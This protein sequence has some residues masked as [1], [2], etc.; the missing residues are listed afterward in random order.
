MRA[1]FFV[2]L[3]VGSVCLVLGVWSLLAGDVRSGVLGVFLAGILFYYAHRR[4]L[5]LGRN[6]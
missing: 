5:R 2:L 4:W 6:P 3:L 1:V